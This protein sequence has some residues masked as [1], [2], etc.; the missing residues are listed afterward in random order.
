MKTTIKGS[1]FVLGHDIDTDQIIPANYLSYNPSIPEERKYFGKYAMAGVPLAQS[2][3]PKGNIPFINGEAFTSQYKIIVGGKNFGCGSS[4][5]HAPLALNEAGIEV[6]IANSFARIFFRN[7]VNGGYLIPYETD[8]DLQALIST[9]EQ[10]EVNLK[11]NSVLRLS[12]GISYDLKPLGDV[13]EILDAGN[14]FAY[15]KSKNMMK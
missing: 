10:L 3:L 15:A 8:V 12:D 9:G 7:S 6:V 2:G 1:T 4:R 13:G 5:E 11:T 14:I